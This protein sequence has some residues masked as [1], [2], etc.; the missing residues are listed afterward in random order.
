MARLN[1]KSTKA[2]IVKLLIENEIDKRDYDSA[3]YA[4]RALI[5]LAKELELDIK[6][7]DYK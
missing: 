6:P 2:A 4:E 1:K 3:E 5:K 7:E